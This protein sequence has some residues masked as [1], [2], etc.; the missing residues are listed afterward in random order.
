MNFEEQ[1]MSKDKY[2]SIFSQ[3]NKGY[4]V[5][6]PSVLKM[7]FPSFSLVQ[8]CVCKKCAHKVEECHIHQQVH[9]LCRKCIQD[10]AHNAQK[11]FVT[12]IIIFE[13]ILIYYI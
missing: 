4:C 10:L 9:I 7:I 5:Y 13:N 8:L 3:P 2:P 12:V 1:I 11:V 6:Y